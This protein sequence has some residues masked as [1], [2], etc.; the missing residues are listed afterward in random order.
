[1]RSSLSSLLHNRN[2]YCF[3]LA[4][5]V[6]LAGTGL[7]TVALSLLAWELAGDNAGSVLGVALALK[8]VAYV[9]LAPV[10]GAFAHKLPRKQ[11][12]IALDVIRLGLV[13]CLPFVT[14]IWQ[15]YL[16]IFVINACSAG[17]T[18]VYQS[19][20]PQILPDQPQYIRALSFSRLAYDLEQLISPVLAAALLSV[21]SFQQ[22]FIA[23]ALTFL[24]SAALLFAVVIPAA[25]APERRRGIWTNLGFGIT[26]YLRTPTLRALLA[27]Y[28]AVASGSAMIIVN[29]VVYVR[30]I[31]DGG[32][33][34]AALG[35]SAAGFGSMLVAL[36]MPSWM[37]RFSPRTLLL[38]GSFLIAVC[39]LAGSL[40]PGW[41]G[42]ILLWALLGMGLS[43]VQT[44]A[45]A[46]VKNAC[47]ESDAPAFFAANFS[48]SH[49]CWF[50]TYLL[51]GWSS[52]LLGL[53]TTFFI[54]AALSALGFVLA[55]KLYPRREGV[56]EVASPQA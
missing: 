33:V 46:L 48:L 50:F 52:S 53:Q 19:V 7:S 8:M 16:L 34:Q 20:L 31:L 45:A 23:D 9:V 6:S 42:F 43:M 51:T 49:F 27:T 28:I 5:V 2:Y 30:N 37:K 21:M 55:L 12:L 4:Q 41:N 54:M 1:M 44:P 18:P 25:A 56:V 29:T 14:A 13:L 22:L 38:Q 47:S 35:L 11:W 26:G 17:F 40:L 24:V 36:L 39:L 10:F 3:F 32:E 15:V